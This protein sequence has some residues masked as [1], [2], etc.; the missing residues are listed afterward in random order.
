MIDLYE[1]WCDESVI[2]PIRPV[3]IYDAQNVLDAFRYMQQGVHMGKI[4]IKMP[5]APS[6][7]A[8]RTVK[9]PFSLSPNLS[10]LL[11]GG[12][13]GLGYSIS[14]WM[15]EMGA[16]HLVYLSPSVDSPKH[17]GFIQ[18]LEEQGCCVP[19]VT[20]SVT[21][22][23]DVQRAISVYPTTRWCCAAL[24][25]AQGTTFRRLCYMPPKS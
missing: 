13:G 10:Y 15:V 19:C 17:R 6:T 20:G 23:E 8:S 12:L 18:E 9:P 16:R 11:V 21:K 5:K 14:T 7:L 22:M 1:S 25:V 4:L 2:T 3:K 24:C